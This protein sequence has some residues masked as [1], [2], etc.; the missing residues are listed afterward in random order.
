MLP[1]VLVFVNHDEI[2]GWPDLREVLTGYLHGESGY[3]DPSSLHISDGMLRGIKERVD[4]YVW[5]DAAKRRATAWIFSDSM[6]EHTRLLKS[7]FRHARHD[8][9]TDPDS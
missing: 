5:I 4:L 2:S 3:L 9:N 7:T 6:P 1:N 8:R